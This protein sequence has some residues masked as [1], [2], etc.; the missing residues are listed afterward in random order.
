MSDQGIENRQLHRVVNVIRT[1][2]YP[3]Y[4]HIGLTAPETFM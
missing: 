1:S 4:R 2:I 3:G